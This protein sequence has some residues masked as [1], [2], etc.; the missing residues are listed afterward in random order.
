[1]RKRHYIALAALVLF[2]LLLRFV[3]DVEERQPGAYIVT[4]VIDGDTMELNGEEKLRLLGI[5]TPEH[6]E[7]FFDD[8]KNFLINM[9]LN[10]QVR[11]ETG[12][13]K[14]DDYGRL[15]GW[16]YIDTILINAEVLKQGLG[17]MYLFPD[18]RNEPARIDR[19]YTAQRA[20]MADQIGIWTLPVIMEEEYYVG[21]S[22]SMRFH[23]P[24][25]E[26][27]AKMSDNNKII[28]ATPEEAFYEGYSPCR[29][30]KP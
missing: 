6:G 15:L 18:N 5:D 12:H 24:A 21:N 2:L 8:A 13:N 26:S 27:A 9:V 20:A 19:L 29:N 3:V 16:V 17:R 28:F 14:R 10:Q 22:R 1:M 25:C 7:P 30:C 4:R 11:I 23:R